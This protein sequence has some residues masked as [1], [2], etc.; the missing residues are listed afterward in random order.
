MSNIN[1][2]RLLVSYPRRF[3]RQLGAWYCLRFPGNA[4]RLHIGCGNKRLEGFVNIDRNPSPAT[5][6]VCH[7]Q[8]L[9]CPDGCVER[10]ETYHVIEHIPFPAVKPLLT[11]W[12]RVLKPGGLLVMECPDFDKAII[13]YLDGNTER[14]F[15][16]YGRLR[17]PG[18]AHHWGYN[19]ERLK[20][21]VESVGFEASILPAQDYHKEH[22]P[23]LRVECTKH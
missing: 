14:L 8:R 10:I 9:P 7:A 15:S 23:C 22:E 2:F 6:Y 11:E 21:L 20:L 13:E 3:S 17:F 4:L 16:V 1:P 5:D 12:K 19:S 18:D